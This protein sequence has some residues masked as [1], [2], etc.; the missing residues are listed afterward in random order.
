MTCEQALRTSD[1][2]KDRDMA[3][4]RA[5]TKK[6]AGKKTAATGSATRK[7]SRAFGKRRAKQAIIRARHVAEEYVMDPEK[8]QHL[9]DEAVGKIER[10]R[11]LLKKAWGGLMAL[12]SLVRAWTKREYREVPWKTV[13]AAVAAI[14]YFV[15]PLDLISDFIPIV[16]Y[17][18]DVT[19]IA[20]TV[21]MIE[22][23]LDQF[24]AWETGRVA[25]GPD[26]S[27]HSPSAETQTPAA[28][29]AVTQGDRKKSLRRR[30]CA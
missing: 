29:P 15:N 17:I 28:P 1:K 11:L 25:N 5:P 3:E 23:D 10:S 30:K 12:C 21:K 26:A 9:L 22:A 27:R 19:I 14:V 4:K 16:G 2:L 24:R 20:L 8:A 6:L 7:K 18:D 13:V